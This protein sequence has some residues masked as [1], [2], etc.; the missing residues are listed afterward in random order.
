M[1]RA[2]CQWCSYNVNKTDSGPH[3]ASSWRKSVVRQV[4]G[5]EKGKASGPSGIVAMGREG[6]AQ[7][8]GLNK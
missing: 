7:A 4:T 2:A 6:R 3:G 5:K 1:Y 8:Q